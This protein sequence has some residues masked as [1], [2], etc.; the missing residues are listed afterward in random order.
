MRSFEE[1]CTQGI[2]IDR[3]AVAA[4]EREYAPSGLAVSRRR[5]R[6][7]NRQTTQGAFSASAQLTPAFG[8]G[9]SRPNL[10]RMIRFAEEWVDERENW[11]LPQELNI[12]TRRDLFHLGIIS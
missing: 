2:E 11:R 1:E 5:R 7:K 6:G 12:M 8:N 4:L 9:F 10:F 3:L